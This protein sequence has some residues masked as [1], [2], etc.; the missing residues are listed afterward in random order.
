ML[1]PD[2][3]QSSLPT[4]DACKQQT[5]APT[6]ADQQTSENSASASITSPADVNNQEAAPLDEQTLAILGDDPSKSKDNEHEIHTAIAARWSGWLNNGINKDD[7]IELLAKYSNAK[8]CPLKGQIL[9]PEVARCLSTSA[10]KRDK[11]SVESQNL[12]GSAMVALGLGITC[13][14]N[15][16]E[17]ID[18]DVLLK[19]LVDAGKLLA[20]VHHHEATSRKATI[21]PGIEKNMK[22][23]L[24]NSKMDVY[25]F[26]KDLGDKIKSEKILEKTASDLKVKPAPKNPLKQQNN[27]NY[28]NSSSPH[29][30]SAKTGEKRTLSFRQK[31]SNKGYPAQVYRA[32]SSNTSQRQNQQS[33]SK[34]ENQPRN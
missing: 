25:L 15:E 23:V 21:L 7:K 2:K 30:A 24:E 20:Q 26:G 8:N 14:L 29:Q 19:Y 17:E 6:T 33:H 13:I 1:D 18:K 27:L 31:S 34:K 9:N 28:R 16:K 4:E 22:A 11:Y 32:Q 12:T 5:V 3:G 10:V